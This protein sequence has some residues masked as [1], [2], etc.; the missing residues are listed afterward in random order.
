MK[1]KTNEE[2]AE[3]IL[4]SNLDNSLKVELIAMIMA[5]DKHVAVPVPV[6]PLYTPDQFQQQDFYNPYKIT[7]KP[8]TGEKIMDWDPGRVSKEKA[9]A[10]CVTSNPVT[11]NSTIQSQWVDDWSKKSAKYL[12]QFA[13]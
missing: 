10:D 6:Y 3:A 7:C 2:K 12:S 13:N 9:E 1:H 11:Y 4:N 5:S 8:T